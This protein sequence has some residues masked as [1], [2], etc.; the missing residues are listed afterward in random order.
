M[1]ERGSLASPVR[2]FWFFG[3]STAEEAVMM[4]QSQ[5]C[6]MDTARDLDFR[7]LLIVI[8]EAEEEAVM[9]EA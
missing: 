4:V 6:E 2:F 7:L 5:C 3:G 9:E 8:R 1:A